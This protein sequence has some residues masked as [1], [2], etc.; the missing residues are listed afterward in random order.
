MCKLYLARGSPSDVINGFSWCLRG[1][2]GDIDSMFNIG[3]LFLNGMGTNK[4]NGKAAYWL[5]QAAN[6][7]RKD[8]AA[9]VEQ[10]RSEG[11]I[12]KI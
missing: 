12:P 8:A 5:Q 6:G 2:E 3:V 11:L 4:D 1:A 7:G 9:A 10:M